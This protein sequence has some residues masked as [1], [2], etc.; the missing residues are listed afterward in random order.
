VI[1]FFDMFDYPLTV[2]EIFYSLSVKCELR[3]VIEA[4]ENMVKPPLIPP[5]E[6]GRIQSPLTPL[7]QGGRIIESKN[8]F[9][10][11]AGRSAIVAERHRRYNFTDRKFKRA[12][13]VSKIFKLIPWIKMIAVGNLLGAHN[14]KD[15]SDIDLFIVAEDKRI[16]LTRF[17]CVGIAKF[18]GLRPQ[19]DNSRDKICL[20][21][22]VSDQAMDLSGLRLKEKNL[23]SLRQLADRGND[24]EESG[25][26]K[27]INPPCPVRLSA[28]DEAPLLKGAEIVDI[29]F[30]YWLAGLT[31]LY[32]AGGTYQKLIKAN[33]R[34]FISLPNW[35][36]VN[37][38]R[39]RQI[40]P[41]L[42]EFYHDLVDLFFGGLEPQ[43]RRAQMKIFPP[44]LKN[45][46][47]Q[48]SRVVINDQIIKLHANDRREEY[49]EKY[50]EK[51][52]NLL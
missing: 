22:Y 31:P 12:L 37:P 5:F 24:K 11:L 3:E 16:W 2:N 51:I 26:D 8:G 4:V 15:D 27:K 32:D 49:R 6:G 18:L 44:A 36:P 43:F 39:Q 50:L 7:Y 30:I 40:K 45:L 38:T 20:S 41:F 17:F 14:L 52:N 1:A 9:Y 35:Q 46:M 33:R 28:H 19:A 21:F 10:F 48:D 25:N 13:L 23:D 42:S 47:N 34:L 29:Y